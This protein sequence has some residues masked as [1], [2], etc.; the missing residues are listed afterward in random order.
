MSVLPINTTWTHLKEIVDNKNL[1]IQYEYNLDGYEIF[2]VDG[3]VV[4]QTVI[5]NNDVP[6]PSIYSQVQNDADKAEFLTYYYSNANLPIV[7][8]AARDGYVVDGN[9]TLIA[10]KDN[11]DVARI[12]NTDSS[13]R[14]VVVGTG[15]AGTPAGGVLTVQGSPSGT[16]IPVSGSVTASNAS[17]GTNDTAAPTSSTQIGGTDGTDL[18]AAKIFD[19]DTGAGT[20]YNLG[21]SIRLP[22][23]GGSVAG[24]TATNP[25][26]IDPTGS[27]SQPVTG[28]VT[29]TQT[30]ATNLNAT[31]QGPA[32]DGAAVI[33]NP[34]LIAGSDGTNVQT[35]LTD[36]YG[37]VV[38]TGKDA[39]GA[40]PTNNPVV[41]AGW[42]GTNVV[43]LRLNSDG[44]VATS[45]KELATFTV[46]GTSIASANNKSMISV[47]NADASLIIKIHEIYVINV[48]TTSAT[49]VVGAFELRRITGHSGGTTLTSVS[50]D[51]S[52]TLDSDITVRTGATVSGES[53]TLMWRSLFSTDE[54]GPGTFDTESSDH[55]FQTMFPIFSRKTDSGTKALTLRQNEGLTVKFAT[56]STTGEF[57]LFLVLTQE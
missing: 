50:M 11:T 57:D 24:G 1:P 26:R 3:I 38:V 52:D 22:N 5:Y 37:S 47:L 33:G 45:D 2:A 35:V 31:V 53:S 23:S 8:N 51:T 7:G 41:V 55:I 32:A 18:H 25:I 13:G 44:T 4:Y 20:D 15:V 54:W 34:V 6:D 27:T 19:L 12:I 21:V 9:A 49:G 17:I 36:G 46:A 40:A 56:N 29:V 39:V 48:R 30:T 28:T 10:G 16:P 43:R 14:T 42:D